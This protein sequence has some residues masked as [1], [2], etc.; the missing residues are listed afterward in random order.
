MSK[1]QLGL[2]SSACAQHGSTM[3]KCACITCYLGNTTVKE[4]YEQ[5]FC[6][7]P[8]YWI[9]L[10]TKVVKLLWYRT[11]TG[12]LVWLQLTNQKTI[13]SLDYYQF[14]LLLVLISKHPFEQS[15]C[16]AI[17][18]YLKVLWPEFIHTAH[19]IQGGVG[20]IV[21]LEARRSFL[22]SHMFC[23]SQKT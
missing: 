14:R 12:S 17:A 7:L 15:H 8:R 4:R 1:G 6:M 18:G 13:T 10:T 3:T 20:K 23:N 11:P 22:N 16:R 5:H 2:T 9:I 21:K 19:S